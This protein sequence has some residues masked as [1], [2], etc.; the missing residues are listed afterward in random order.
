MDS[1][2]EEKEEKIEVEPIADEG[3]GVRDPVDKVKKLKSELERTEKERREYL[4]G[5]QRAKAEFINYK[6]DE[7]KR[8]EEIGQFIAAGIAAELLQVL[9]SF[10]LALVNIPE[11]SGRGIILIQSQLEDILR[12]HGLEEIAVKSGDEFRPEEQESLGE[13]ESE[14]RAGAV[15]QVLQ[16][17]YK[18]RGRVLRPAR[19]KLSKGPVTSNQ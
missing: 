14:V 4:D 5:W 8:F 11:E 2:Q 16:K 18:F 15:A 6:K 12:K 10:N 3:A 19:V 9:D 7:G 17:G 1:D 13:T